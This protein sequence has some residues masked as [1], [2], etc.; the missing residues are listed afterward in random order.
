MPIRIIA[1]AA[2]ARAME[3]GSSP[4]EAPA[5]AAA[6]MAMHGTACERFPSWRPRSASGRQPIARDGLG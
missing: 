1:S 5:M 4:T 6:K 3:K 2:S